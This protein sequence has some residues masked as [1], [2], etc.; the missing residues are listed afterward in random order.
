MYMRQMRVSCCTTLPSVTGLI[1]GLCDGQRADQIAALLY[2]KASLLKQSLSAESCG[3]PEWSAAP[4]SVQK[5][6]FDCAGE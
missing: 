6:Q 1:Y 2:A 5:Q 4:N 3:I